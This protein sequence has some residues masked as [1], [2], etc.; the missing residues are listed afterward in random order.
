MREVNLK[1]KINSYINLKCQYVLNVKIEFLLLL[2][3]KQ[4]CHKE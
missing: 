3:I 4:P 1:P 2:K